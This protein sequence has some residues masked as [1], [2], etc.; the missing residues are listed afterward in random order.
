MELSL[1]LRWTPALVCR[2][3]S[4]SVQKIVAFSVSLADDLFALKKVELAEA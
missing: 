1:M 2:K 3:S 4:L